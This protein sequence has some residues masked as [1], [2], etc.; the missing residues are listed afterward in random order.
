MFI[1][2]IMNALSIYS[3]D[4]VNKYKL[5]LEGGFNKSPFFTQELAIEL[6]YAAVVNS[7]LYSAIV[8]HTPH[9]DT[10]ITDRIIYI[11]GSA[12]TGKTS[13]IFPTVINLLKNSN[14]NLNT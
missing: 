5:H 7:E 6:A 14:P 1:N 11:L 9:L 13:T 12:G 8:E 4:Y 10:N 3:I 2:D